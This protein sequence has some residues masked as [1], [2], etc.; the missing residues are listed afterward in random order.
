MTGYTFCE[1]FPT[2][3]EQLI[4]SSLAGIEHPVGDF[5]SRE[6]AFSLWSLSLL[7]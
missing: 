3:Y 6:I 2:G 5:S 4:N 1:V 7:C